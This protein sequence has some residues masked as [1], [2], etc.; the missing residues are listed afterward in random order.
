[1]VENEKDLLRTRLEIVKERIKSAADSVNRNPSSIELVVVTKGKSASI[2]KDLYDLGIR[3][4]GESYLKEALFKIDLLRDYEI[5][6]HMIGTIQRGKTKSIADHFS[7]IQSVDRYELAAAIADRAAQIKKVIPVYLEVNLS[8]ERTKHGWDISSEVGLELFLSEV[9]KILEIRS[10]ELR[11]LMMMAPYSSNPEDSRKYFRKLKDI[12]DRMR[13]KFSSIGYL[14]L[15]MGM[16]GDFEVA[17]QEG[18][19]MLRIGSAIVG[20]R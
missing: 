12:R 13:E 16:S 17:I 11:G 15:S 20:A 8:G 3:S 14:G 7:Q 2:I 1:M 9:N 10:I 19:T 6:W 4:I 5:N 18:A